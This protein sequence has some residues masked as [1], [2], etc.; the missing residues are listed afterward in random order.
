MT[1]QDYYDLFLP[2]VEARDNFKPGHLQQ[3]KILCG[4]F[5]EY[6][7]LMNVIREEGYTYQSEG[8]NGFQIKPKPEVA[9]LNR[10]RAEIANYSKMLNLV[11]HKDKPTP[12]V[13]EDEWE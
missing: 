5:V 2:D 8:R 9:Q 4:L 10:T 13:E 11:L 1:F 12:K 6:D 7:Y 3:L